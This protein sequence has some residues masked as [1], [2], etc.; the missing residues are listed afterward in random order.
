M[1]NLRWS[2]GVGLRLIDNAR[3]F[4]GRLEVGFSEEGTQF[5]LKGS[6][7][8]QFAKGGLFNGVVPVPTW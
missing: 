7:N 3:S 8:F 1:A 6:Q 4:S 2:W 5:R